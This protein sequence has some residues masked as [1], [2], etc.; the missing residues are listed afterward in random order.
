MEEAKEYTVANSRDSCKLGI[1]CGVPQG[2]ILGP[3]LFLVYINDI[4]KNLQHTKVRLYADDTVIYNSC[5]QIIQ[6][7]IHLQSSLDHLYNWCNRNK[8]TVNINK[9]KIMTFGLRQFIKQR[10]SPLLQ[11]GNLSLG[12]VQTFKYLGF[13]LDRELKFSAHAQNVYK[14]ASY[15]IIPLEKSDH[16]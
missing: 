8:L 2:S 4:C 10:V 9:T 1:T 15:K 3:L 7:G 11:M 14:L 6:T 12:N 13:I 5:D 16:I